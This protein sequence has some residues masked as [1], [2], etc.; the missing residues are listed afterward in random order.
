M[1]WAGKIF[2]V[3]CRIVG[4][5]SETQ[6]IVNETLCEERLWLAPL[7][8]LSGWIIGVIDGIV[9][10]VMCNGW[11]LSMLLLIGGNTIW[12]KD[13][14]VVVSGSNSPNDQFLSSICFIQVLI[15]ASVFSN[16]F[17]LLPN[18]SMILTALAISTAVFVNPE[19]EDKKYKLICSWFKSS[20]PTVMDLT[21]TIKAL[22]D[23]S[24]K[25]NWWT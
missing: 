23:K 9:N 3:L 25:D 24:K 21:H 11:N 6:G 5:L 12:G 20:K 17:F 14:V 7:V 8:R 22:I 19:F 18:F 10:D 4:M 2:I 16:L 15:F 13:N 1:L